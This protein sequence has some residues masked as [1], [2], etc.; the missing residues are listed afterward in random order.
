M[1]NLR[2]S[3]RCALTLALAGAVLLSACG[4]D[5]VADP[6][7]A[8][9][10]APAAGTR[11]AAAPVG[12]APK[13]DP[14]IVAPAGNGQAKCNIETIAGQLLET[15]PPVIPK[16]SAASLAGWYVDVAG[17]NAG[18]GLLLVIHNQDHSKSWVVPVSERTDRQDVADS[19]DGSA[20]YVKS[21][22][23][24]ALDLSS[25]PVGYYGAYLTDSPASAGV[26]ALG[27]TFGLE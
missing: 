8:A 3:Q 16:A 4:K 19:I 20:G 11:A 23:S 26:C 27:R 9:P 14:S 10:D 18:N 22:F 1:Y 12:V 2:Q 17:K 21:G 15:S 24:F 6:E 5:P 7:S 25:L 13:L